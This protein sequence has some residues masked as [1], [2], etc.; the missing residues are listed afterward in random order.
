MEILKEKQGYVAE[1]LIKNNQ[2]DADLGREI[3]KIFFSDPLVMRFPNNMELGSE[4]RKIYRN[5]KK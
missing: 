4:I 2:N 1:Y 3:R 5:L